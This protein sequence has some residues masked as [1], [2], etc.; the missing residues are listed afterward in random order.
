MLQAWTHRI[1]R[2]HLMIVLKCNEMHQLLKKELSECI[3]I[4]KI[5]KTENVIVFSDM[6]YEKILLEVEHVSANSENTTTG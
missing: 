6:Y 3:E 2:K 5:I 4:G 1:W